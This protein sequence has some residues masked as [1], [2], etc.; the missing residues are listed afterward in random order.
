MPDDLAGGA[1]LRPGHGLAL[2]HED[3]PVAQLMGEPLAGFGA[4]LAGEGGEDFGPLR[5]RRTTFFRA[6]PIAVGIEA[7]H[8][9][10]A[11]LEIEA[12]VGVIVPAVEGGEFE[13][14]AAHRADQR[15]G[16]RRQFGKRIAEFQ[17]VH[18]QLSDMAT[19]LE[20]GRHLVYHAAWLAQNGHP[21]GKEAAIAKLFCSEL[22]MRNTIKAIQLHGGYGYTK[23]YPVERMMRDAKITQIYEGTNQIQ[24]LVIARQLLG[25]K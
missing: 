8:P 2:L 4:G 23:D 12:G 14:V 10:L 3:L 21:Y 17:G 13:F 5:L 11:A 6:G 1:E 24:R 18:F 25:K 9:P 7:G 15:I 16:E 19:E 20:A 22:A